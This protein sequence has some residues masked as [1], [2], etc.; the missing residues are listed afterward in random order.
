[1]DYSLYKIVRCAGNEDTITLR[2]RDNA[3]SLFLTFVTESENV[4]IVGYTHKH[5]IGYFKII[6]IKTEARV[7]HETQPV[8]ND[9]FGGIDQEKVS[10]YITK[11]MDLDVEQL[12]IPVS[13]PYF[14]AVLTF[15]T[16]SKPF[17]CQL[18]CQPCKI[19]FPC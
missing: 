7:S 13:R 14:R 15:N 4:K 17:P 3:D 19:I 2:F 9:C 5:T 11:L 16:G 8:N 1:M 12:S 10:D 6:C 18:C